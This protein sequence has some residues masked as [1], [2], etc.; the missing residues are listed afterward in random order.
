MDTVATDRNKQGFCLSLQFYLISQ[1]I[2]QTNQ[3]MS[4]VMQWTAFL[5]YLFP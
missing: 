2:W 4:F 3:K 5:L 1:P